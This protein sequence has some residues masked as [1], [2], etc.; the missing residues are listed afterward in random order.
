M[1]LQNSLSLDNR[2]NDVRIDSFA[3]K[4]YSYNELESLLNVIRGQNIE[5]ETQRFGVRIEKELKRTPK[6]VLRICAKWVDAPWLKWLA[7]MLNKNPVH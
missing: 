6:G 4:A 7:S 5:G 1:Q 2:I 3:F